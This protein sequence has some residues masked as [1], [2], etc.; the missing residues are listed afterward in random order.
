M[1]Y[2]NTEKIV[3]SLIVIVGVILFITPILSHGKLP[4]GADALFHAHLAD[5]VRRGFADG[6]VFPQWMSE[7]N[8]GFGS[9]ALIFYP[10]L[11]PYIVGLLSHLTG[12][13][14]ASALRYVVLVS[15]FLCAVSFYYAAREFARRWLSAAGAFLYVIGPYYVFDLYERFAFAEYNAFIFIPLVFKFQRRL[16][17]NPTRLNFIG[18][19]VAAAALSLTH[20]VVTYMAAFCIIPYAFALAFRK[21]SYVSLVWLASAGVCSLFLSAG[22]LL[23]LILERNLIHWKE[24]S[25][26]CFG[27]VDRNFLFSNEVIRGYVL[28]AAKP[29]LLPTFV[30]QAFLLL[31]ALPFLCFGKRGRIE[32][33]IL[34]A[35]GLMASLLQL[36]FSSWFW[37]NL[38]GMKHIVFPWRF[39]LFQSFF[40]IIFAIWIL[41]RRPH[42]SAYVVI[43]LAALYMAVW[44][45][46]KYPI[47]D[48]TLDQ[49]LLNQYRFRQKVQSEHIP[50]G[51]PDYRLYWNPSHQL[52]SQRIIS[53]DGSQ[54]KVLR[55]NSFERQMLVNSTESKARIKL[56]T[57]YFPNWRARLNEIP[58]DIKSDT[59]YKAI[60]VDVPKGKHLLYLVFEATRV[61]TI[62]RCI[63]LITW[64]VVFVFATISLRNRFR[65]REK[66]T[67]VFSRPDSAPGSLD[68][69]E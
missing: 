6:V 41:S 64:L 7:A 55:W 3:A 33:V 5:G 42:I 66:I 17:L 26:S 67:S 60:L 59:M 30:V 4:F 37:H 52:P 51:V 36:P 9:P 16:M 20:V 14:I 68:P 48:M 11:G 69:R 39:L 54:V 44:S 22:Y 63:S 40:S 13:S 47:S 32:G 38:P 62:S 24:V 25:E 28:A 2:R 8:R 15:A 50:V 46:N 27:P 19:A 43:G 34:A 35:I 10:P 45:Y 1:R 29:H 23:P 21:R 65:V 58:I 31:V 12:L 56:R 61:R 57:F 18:F 49:S 53:T